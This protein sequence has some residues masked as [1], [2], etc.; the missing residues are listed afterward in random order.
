MKADREKRKINSRTWDCKLIGFEGN[1]IF[2][3]I[4]NLDQKLI[5]ATDVHFENDFR[6]RKPN[7]LPTLAP[8]SST[9]T[10]TQSLAS[11]ST[12][13]PVQKSVLFNLP[14]NQVNHSI[15][16]AKSRLVIEIPQRSLTRSSY[17]IFLLDKCDSLFD[18]AADPVGRVRRLSRL[19]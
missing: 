17:P 14:A 19:R 2:R 9:I 16:K 5:R 15:A 7:P 6:Y 12:D 4:R 18:D 10:N 1:N 11:P 13:S 8:P 3:L